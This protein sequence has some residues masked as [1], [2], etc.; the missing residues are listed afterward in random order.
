M[1]DP[2][3]YTCLV[4]ED[5]ESLPGT[6][7]VVGL[8]VVAN[9]IDDCELCNLVVLPDYVAKS[10]GYGLLQACV[11]VARHFK[12]PRMLLEVRQ[13]NSRA[14]E[15]YKRNGFRITSER[16]NYYVNP[17]ENAWVMERTVEVA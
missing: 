7:A 4:A 5:T 10:V 15:F 9:L 1:G 3:V 12:I 8:A 14:I 2:R 13:S 11:E 16:K 17:N 6:E